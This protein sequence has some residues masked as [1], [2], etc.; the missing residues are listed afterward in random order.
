MDKENC[1]STISIIVPVY[2]T[3]SYLRNCIDSVLRQKYQNWEL[4]LVDD[5]STDGSGRIC[6][7]YTEKD[8]RIRV[9]HKPNSG[10]SDARNYGLDLVKGEWI[11]F[12][13]SDDE[14]YPDCLSLMSLWSKNCDMVA[15]LFEVF[16]HNR[17]DEN[18]PLI[19]KRSQIDKSKKVTSSYSFVKSLLNNRKGF[20]RMVFPKLFKNQI[21]NRYH[22][23]FDKNIYY[24][25]D[26]LLLAQYICCPETKIIHINDKTPV[27]KYNLWK[28]NATSKKNLAFNNKLFTEFL[29]FNQIYDIYHLKFHEKVIDDLAKQDVYNSGRH[30][31]ELIEKTGN[32]SL[33]QKT[34]IEENLAKLYC[35]GGGDRLKKKYEGKHN[36]IVMKQGAVLKTKDER[37][38]IIHEWLH[39]SECYYS[40]L[41]VR[42]KILYLLSHL[43]GKIGVRLVVD[44]INFS[45]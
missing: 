5:G 39:S 16:N 28:G 15:G 38:S 7:E 41:N 17:N 14:I 33:A 27:Y 45:E 4:I 32:A 12:L 6:D 20:P 25:E 36:F 3:K 44:K 19:E 24:A 1:H 9:E 10:V 2:N 42:W 21:I 35:K 30:L 29:A 37:I 23:R 34:Y 26:Q 13:D 22:L 43:F 8:S 18:L 11:F 31:I 40:E